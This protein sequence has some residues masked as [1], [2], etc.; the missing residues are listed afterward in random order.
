M[1]FFTTPLLTALLHS[2]AAKPVVYLTAF[3]LSSFAKSCLIIIITSAL[4]FPQNINKITSTVMK[5]AKKAAPAIH[6]T[7]GEMVSVAIGYLKDRKSSSRQAISKYIKGAAI[8]I[9]S[10]A[11]PGT[12][13]FL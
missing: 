11:T 13:R 7:Y 1:Q 9:I 6:P 4:C 3:Y 8:I 2:C 5:V 12:D 10:N